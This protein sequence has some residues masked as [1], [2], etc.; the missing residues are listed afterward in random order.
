MFHLQFIYNL[1]FYFR[2]FSDV[3]NTLIIVRR[4]GSVVIIFRKVSEFPR[5]SPVVYRSKTI[6]LIIFYILFFRTPQLNSV[7][8]SRF[9]TTVIMQH[10]H[11]NP[12]QCFIPVIWV[13]A[14]FHHLPISPK[15]FHYHVSQIQT[16]QSKR[17]ESSSNRCRVCARL[18]ARNSTG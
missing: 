2:S 6:L 12:V 14:V 10:T 18:V 13:G 4:K 1:G 16:H 3:A 9:Q 15:T 7:D 8:T 17:E 11:E 5:H